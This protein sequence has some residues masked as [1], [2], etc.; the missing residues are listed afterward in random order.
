MSFIDFNAEEVEPNAAPEALPAGDYVAQVV[1]SEVKPT[2]SGSGEYLKLEIEILSPG[3]SG[4]RVFDQLN[5][6]NDSPEA[7]RIGRAQLSALCH[8]IGVMRVTDSQQLHGKPFT[9]KLAVK[10]DPQ[11]GKQNKV[12]GYKA[13]TA[14]PQAAPIHPAASAPAAARP[15]AAVPPWQRSKMS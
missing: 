2:A 8:A 7:E 13:A 12:K 14:T 10:E 5:I 9:I 4:R 11:Y 6:R 15:A 1:G 3:F